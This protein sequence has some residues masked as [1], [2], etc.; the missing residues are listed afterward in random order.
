MDIPSLIALSRVAGVGPRRLRLLVDRFGDAAA[1]FDRTLG[2]L[3]QVTGLDARTARAITFA[4]PRY[5]ADARTAIIRR[6]ERLQQRGGVV[7]TLWDSA[8]PSALRAIHDAPPLLFV[9]GS[10]VASDRRMLAIVGTRRPSPY[11][12]SCARE[13]SLQ[14][15]AAGFTV[16]SG[17]ARGIDTLAHSGALEAGGYTIGILGSGIDVIYPPENISLAERVVQRGAIVSE[18]EPGSQPH[19]SHFPRR[20]RI[21]SGLTIG[22]LVIETGPRGGAMITASL[23][24]EQNR[25]VFAVPSGVDPRTPSGT[26]LLIKRGEALLVESPED[27]VRELGLLI[28]DSRPLSDSGINAS[29]HRP[30]P[31]AVPAS[32]R[33]ERPER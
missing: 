5:S 15:A 7:V 10:I 16:V 23:A 30:H 19:A 13:F 12:I 14:L 3:L 33:P 11:G 31:S 21:I 24:L 29:V 1:V 25:E 18:L 20:N 27:I 6:L 8:Y 28:R 9:R 26:N 22:T 4:G 2:E 32:G 17:L